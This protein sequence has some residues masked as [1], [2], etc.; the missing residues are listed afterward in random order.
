M[1]VLNSTRLSYS[2]EHMYIYIDCIWWRCMYVF[3]CLFVSLCDD[4]KT[5]A[6]ICFLLGGYLDWR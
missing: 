5:I 1:Y 4:L 3:V 6:D 2:C